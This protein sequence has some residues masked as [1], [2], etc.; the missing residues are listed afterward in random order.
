MLALILLPPYPSYIPITHIYPYIFSRF[1]I[2]GGV[3]PAR[4]LV[5]GSLT[6]LPVARPLIHKL[7]YLRDALD[8]E[9]G[10]ILREHPFLRIFLQFQFLLPL[11]GQQ[12][13]DVFIVYLRTP[14][15]ELRG[16][17][18]ALL[19]VPEHMLERIRNDASFLWVF[20]QPHHHV[21]LAAT[22]LPI[23]E[24]RPVVALNHRFH[25]GKRTLVV[26][27]PLSGRPIVDGVISKHFGDVGL[28]RLIQNPLVQ[29]PHRGDYLRLVRA[30]LRDK[31]APS[32]SHTR[33][34][35]AA[36]GSQ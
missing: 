1:D 25:Q 31:Q 23:R 13:P 18:P 26:Y 9:R 12:V 27:L 6:H 17:I 7:L 8:Y 22:R 30:G 36:Q 4:V 33:S 11:F 3:T 21:R 5:H 2:N 15:Q 34:F 19:N 16:G 28:V 35:D 29:I 14:Y 20:L 10:Q 24:Y 32:L